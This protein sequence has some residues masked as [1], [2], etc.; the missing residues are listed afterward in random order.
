[1]TSIEPSRT[2]EDVTGI[3]K[4]AIERILLRKDGK[5]SFAS[6]WNVTA[7]QAEAVL[8]T[9]PRGDVIVSFFAGPQTVGDAAASMIAKQVNYPIA[10]G[11]DGSLGATTDAV[12]SGYGLEWSGG[13]TGDGMLTT[14]KQSFATGTVDGTSIDLGSVS[15]LFGAAAYLHVVTMPSGTLQVTVQDSANNSTWADVTGLAFTA[16]TGPT[17]ERKQTATNAT[18]RRYVRVECSGTHGTSL[19]AVNFIRYLTDPSV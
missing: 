2:D 15:T 7:G 5:I 6:F 11:A 8:S 18:I 10:R 14:G 1:V 16:A 17:S 3:D 9:A 4:S 19:V 13:W 12:G